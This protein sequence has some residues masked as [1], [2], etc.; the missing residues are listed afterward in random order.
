MPWVWA[1]WLQCNTETPARL[2]AQGS[3]HSLQGSGGEPA[4]AAPGG[5][6]PTPSF[7]L[8]CTCTATVHGYAH[9]SVLHTALSHLELQGNYA[10]L[11]FVDFSSAFNTILPNMLV[12][13][14][15]DLGISHSVCLWIK[16][17]LTDRSQSV[18]V[19]SHISS[20]LSLST[21]SPRGC[22]L[23]PLLYTL[24]TH[25]CTPVHASNTIINPLGT[26]VILGPLRC[27]DMSWYLCLFQLLITY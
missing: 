14:L 13:K 21:G 4:S 22:V 12:S 17:F 11:L 27:F 7:A 16:D 5:G 6:R 25:D 20:A 3:C 18:R 2:C 9:C 1:G 19:G 26:E 23:S 15:S 10:R 8:S 24:Y